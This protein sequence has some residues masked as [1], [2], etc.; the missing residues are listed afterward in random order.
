[1]VMVDLP[2]PAGFVVQREPLE[3]L[4]QNRVIEKYEVTSQQLIVYLRELRP[5]REV[6]I[7]YQL[8]A[9]MP[10]E[11]NVSGATVYEYYDPEKR[12]RSNNVQLQVLPGNSR[13]DEVTRDGN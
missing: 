11:V 13:A 6:K 8:Q 4:V 1:M 12:A 10:V 9:T 5:D 7:T 2:I 3:K